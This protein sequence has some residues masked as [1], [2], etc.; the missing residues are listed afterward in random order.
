MHRI[1]GRATMEVNSS[2]H[3]SVKKLAR[4]LVTSA[5]APDGV[6]EAIESSS[7]P[8]YLG[9]QWHPECLYSTDPIQKRLFQ[10]LVKAARNFAP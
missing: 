1:A 10:A 7:H 6:I 5:A 9:V 4:L 8:F 2:H 3:Q